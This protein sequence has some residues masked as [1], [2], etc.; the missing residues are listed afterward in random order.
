MTHTYDNT[1]AQLS[2]NCN[3][4]GVK[5]LEFFS[6]TEVAKQL[7]VSKYT[8]RSWLRDGK[9]KGTKLVGDTWRVSDEDLKQ[10]I[11]EGKKR[12]NSRRVTQKS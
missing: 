6:V 2:T 12:A 1:I 9:I 10:F 4:K 5:F 7:K 3:R 11:E 8:L